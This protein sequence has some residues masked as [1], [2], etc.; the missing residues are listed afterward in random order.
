LISRD[1]LLI[2]EWILTLVKIAIKVG[3]E[4]KSEVLIANAWYGGL[5]YSVRIY[6]SQEERI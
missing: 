5:R 6:S 1:D 4:E 3:R 2:A